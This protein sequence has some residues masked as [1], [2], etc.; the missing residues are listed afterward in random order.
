[1]IILL[2]DIKD[3]NGKRL[4]DVGL[5]L[6]MKSIRPDANIA[7]VLYKALC[8]PILPKTKYKNTRSIAELLIASN[9]VDARM[10][11]VDDK[12]MGE[13]DLIISESNL[14]AHD[15]LEDDATC[16]TEYINKNLP[17]GI[18]QRLSMDYRP[19]FLLKVDK[20]QY[21]INTK[22][23]SYS[24]FTFASDYLKDGVYDAKMH[25]HIVWL[26][27]TSRKE[28]AQRENRDMPNIEAE[29]KQLEAMKQAS[30][31]EASC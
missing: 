31:K 8:R 3:H 25:D 19:L 14:S 30:F 13:C 18:T 28:I 27:E 2:E 26:G 21:I 11:L 1:M 22:A 12:V 16:I 24:F 29:L 5:E 7:F 6:D 17:S 4:P 9:E 20:R 10:V 15:T 23:L